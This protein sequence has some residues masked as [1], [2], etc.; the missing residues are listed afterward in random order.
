MHT[1]YLALVSVGIELD[2]TGNIHRALLLPYDL[3]IW[4]SFHRSLVMKCDHYH[5]DWQVWVA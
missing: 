1:I 2:H 5:D 3:P 4:I